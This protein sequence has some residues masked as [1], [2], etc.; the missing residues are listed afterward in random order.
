MKANRPK[1]KYRL[2]EIA[3]GPIQLLIFD[4]KGIPYQILRIEREKTE[5]VIGINEEIDRELVAIRPDEV[6]SFI[7]SLGVFRTLLDTQEILYYRTGLFVQYGEQLIKSITE[8]VMRGKCTTDF[9]NEVSNH[10]R[11][12]TYTAREAFDKN[13]EI[14]N[15]ANGL[16]DV[17]SRV[18]V[19]HR[20]LAR[21]NLY[22]LSRVQL[23]RIYNPGLRPKAILNF[24]KQVQPDPDCRRFVLEDAASC[25]DKKPRRRRASFYV[26]T[27]NGKNGKTTWSNVLTQCLGERN[28]SNLPL[29]SLSGEDR[30]ITAE[31]EGKLL[32]V[33]GEIRTEEIDEVGNY[34]VLTG[35]DRLKGERKYKDPF[36]FMP[37]AKYIFM[38]NELPVLKDDLLATYD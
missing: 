30:F 1:K 18:I 7:M 29:K 24:L 31:L 2:R 33:Y 21:F 20:M 25:L 5:V 9:R 38:A 27:L 4:R 35:A 34:R 3:F 11:T 22:Y 13:A 26:G 36:Y 23:P 28:V 14:V 37:F 32:N 17:Q 8:H 12:R 10:I 15:C 16:I 6:A 19:P